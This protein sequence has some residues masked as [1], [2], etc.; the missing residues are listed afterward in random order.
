M[1]GMNSPQSCKTPSSPSQAAALFP[2]FHTGKRQKL[3]YLSWAVRKSI[4]HLQARTTPQHTCLSDKFYCDQRLLSDSLYFVHNSFHPWKIMH[5]TE[6]SNLLS[7]KASW[8][9]TSTSKLY[10]IWELPLVYLL[11]LKT[12]SVFSV[13][14]LFQ[15]ASIQAERCKYFTW[16]TSPALDFV[17][18]PHSF[19]YLTYHLDNLNFSWLFVGLENLTSITPSK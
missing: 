17:K 18:D 7:L 3:S 1:Q 11:R 10:Q 14:V 5:P 13:F 12:I 2:M 4:S 6:Y 9:D 15:H 8:H 16:H 19:Y